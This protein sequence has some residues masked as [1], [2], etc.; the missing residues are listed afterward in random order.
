MMTAVE[1]SPFVR[2]CIKA[3]Y[4]SKV[5]LVAYMPFGYVNLAIFSHYHVL[6]IPLADL[7]NI[8]KHVLPNI[9][10]LYCG[11]LY[12]T[13]KGGLRHL[14]LAGVRNFTVIY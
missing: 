9:C 11:L 1:F 5:K 14:L 2:T 10:T 3:L 4:R 8:N 12:G 6:Q 7:T 13:S